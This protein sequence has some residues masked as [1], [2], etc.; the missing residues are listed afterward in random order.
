MEPFSN[1]EIFDR[2]NAKE[3]LS[4]CFSVTG[5]CASDSPL[6]IISNFELKKSFQGYDPFG[7][8]YRNISALYYSTS[9]NMIVVFFAGTAHISEWLD[10]FDFTQEN[11]SNI[12][13]DSTIL[14]HNEMYKIYDSFRCDL[15]EEIK[16]LMNDQTI[17]IS[18]GHS[19]GGALSTICY[20]DI[21]TNNIIKNRALYSFASP[22][23]GN[24]EFV[25]ILN[26]ENTVFRIANSY[27][28]AVA[29]PLPILGSCIYSHFNNCISFSTN[30]G[31]TYM[32]HGDAYTNF[33]L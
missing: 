14:V 3:L 11:P 12:T 31:Q 29:V 10:D 9:L 33:F 8:C 16:N 13:S 1:L 24:V 27:D 4:N 20:F 25:T 32:N 18:S 26:R 7:I 30:L 19:L 21:A 28:L 23:V 22:R 15:I 2:N 6:P 5:W 17:F